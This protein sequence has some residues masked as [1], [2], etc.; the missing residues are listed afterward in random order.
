MYTMHV[1]VFGGKN[2]AIPKR[3][4]I[5]NRTSV[6]PEPPYN[7]ILVKIIILM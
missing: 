4:S 5:L 2:L 6:A 3:Y 7:T 1:V